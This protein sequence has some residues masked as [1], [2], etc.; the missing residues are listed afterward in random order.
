MS[1]HDQERRELSPWASRAGLVLVVLLVG[2]LALWVRAKST[3]GIGLDPPGS[4]VEVDGPWGSYDPDTLY[5][6][7]RVE[8]GV[9]D[10]GWIAAYDPLLAS[11][12]ELLEPEPQPGSESLPL[13]D[14]IMGAPI[15]WPPFY[16][17]LLTAIYRRALPLAGALVDPDAHPRAEPLGRAERGRLERFVASV[18][19]VFGA[20]AAMLAA[21]IA[22]GRAR[23]LTGQ[24]MLESGADPS[25]LTL[26][27]AALA[28]AAIAGVTFAL[29]FGHIRY[30][31]LGNG[32][33]HAFISL[34]HI[35]MLGVTV[36]ALDHE[37]IVQPFWS[38][39]RGAFAGL[40]AAAMITSWTASILPV[41][42]VQLA[43]VI[44]LVVPFRSRDGRRFS[45][46]GLPVFATS[47]HKAALLGVVPAVIDSPFSNLKPWS[48]VELSWLH[49]A[50]LSVGWLIFAPYA[51]M[52]KTAAKS[53]LVAFTP[54]VLVALA[55]V[56]MTPAVESLRGAFSWAS[57]GNSF[58]S[59]INESRALL[60]EGQGWLP[61]LKFAG[62]GVLAAPF[63]WFS[64]LRAVGRMP[65]LLPLVVVL[66]VAVVAALF[67]RRFAESLAGP[68]A[69]ALGSWLAGWMVAAWSRR[70]A[71]ADQSAAPSW[72]LTLAVILGATFAAALNPWT[73]RNTRGF[74]QREAST[75]AAFPNT[76]PSA[77][78]E[79]AVARFLMDLRTDEEPPPSVLA[80]WDLGHTIE[81]RAGFGT[82]ATNFGLYVGEDAFLDPWRFFSSTDPEQAEALL[83]ARGVRYV[84][85]DGDRNRASMG[86]ALARDG[87]TGLEPSALED[88]AFWRQ[89]MAARLLRDGSGQ[90]ALPVPGFLSLVAA[91]SNG[92]GGTIELYER[93]EGAILEATEAK[94]LRVVATLRG[95]DG[96]QVSWRASASSPDGPRALRIRV[97]YGSPG[98]RGR[99][100]LG[101]ALTA[102]VEALEIYVDGVAAEVEVPASAVRLGST[103]VVGR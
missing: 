71:S 89:T 72:K 12:A 88:P 79:A 98:D 6:A 56:F 53:Q 59:S 49:L 1:S 69:V 21:L 2:A 90:A 5:H 26:V 4:A 85:M 81:W 102:P 27:A 37:R 31:H 91:G 76:S 63:V 20:L 40:L 50:W 17:L 44:R 25:S 94:S 52:P 32:D 96:T 39:A 84:L 60:G 24:R 48:L 13:I 68:M 83:A 66:P 16:D 29:N 75:G 67:Q 11:G 78:K 92:V 77:K 93:V 14:P 64:W 15:P 7:R 10:H 58:M 43:L 42:L 103:V 3:T 95:G 9:R 97:P 33:H 57:A 51:L 28:A 46:R 61:L 23:R 74:L 99:I 62:I 55:T 38:A 8:R 65:S 70:T 19:M 82:V 34:L 36:R 41:G 100:D 18:P 73:L 101:P 80:H 47:F 30:S 35:A 45:A 54:A 22:A 86:A 87:K